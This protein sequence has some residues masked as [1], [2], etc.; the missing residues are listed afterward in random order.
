MNKV[1]QGIL[2]RPLKDNYGR[3]NTTLVRVY[4]IWKRVLIVLGDLGNTIQ[5]GNR[6]S[7]TEEIAA[8]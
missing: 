5:E 6:Y 7:R 1:R 4:L 8:E 3:N 2:S